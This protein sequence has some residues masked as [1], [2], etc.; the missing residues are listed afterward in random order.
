MQQETTD[1]LTWQ[2]RFGTDETYLEA[3]AA[4]RV[5]SNLERYR[6]EIFHGASKEFTF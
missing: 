4:H 2:D 6:M 5:T 1:F 3:I